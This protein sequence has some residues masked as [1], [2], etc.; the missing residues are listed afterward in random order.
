MPASLLLGMHVED[1]KTRDAKLKRLPIA[2]LF[3]LLYRMRGP[4]RP[5]AAEREGEGGPVIH[6]SSVGDLATQRIQCSHVLRPG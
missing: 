2:A 3:T 5:P 4:R 1:L 6:P